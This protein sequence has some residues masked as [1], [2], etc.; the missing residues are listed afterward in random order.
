MEGNMT[1][2]KIFRLLTLLQI[3]SG[4]LFSCDSDR[5]IDPTDK[6][7]FVKYYGGNGN[8]SGV[9]MIENG[10]GTFLLLGNW[11]ID[12]TENRIYLVNVDARGR[13]VWEK[14]LGT[15]SERAKDIERT[16]DGNFVILSDNATASDT[17][18]KLI[19]INPQGEKIDSVV[20]GSPGNENAHSV[21]SLIDGGFIIAGATE[22]DSSMVVNP[23]NPEDISDIFHY[24]CNADLVFDKFNWYEQYGPGTFDGGTKVIQRSPDQFYVFGFSNQTHERNPSGRVNLLYYAIGSGGIIQGLNFL[25]DVDNDT[26][27]AFAMEVPVE[28][29]GGFFIAGTETTSAGSINLHVS[30][31]R[32]PLIFNSTNDEL[33][34]RSIPIESRKLSSLAAA[35]SLTGTQGYLLLANELQDDGSNNIWLTK[36]DQ[37]SGS[38]VWSATFGSDEEDDL[39]AAVMQ[40][41]DGKILL[42]GTIG[43]INNQ[44]KMVLMKL[45][46]TG[47]LM[48]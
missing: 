47:Q 42:L 44:S 17:D 21:S 6:N 7:Y 30:K 25:G 5:S 15:T 32:D 3:L 38:I 20:Y 40:L 13:I 10:E 48:N 9:D 36:I 23:S 35:P 2:R 22:Y 39:G 12:R 33:F 46:S 27:S 26:E 29:G 45:N 31:L 18:V 34:D 28:L 8:Q 4:L 11:Q 37:G 24:R 43:L 19:I 41:P 1:G 14:K 16:N